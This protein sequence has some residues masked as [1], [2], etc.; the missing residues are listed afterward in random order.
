MWSNGGQNRRDTRAHARQLFFIGVQ[1]LYYLTCLAVA[2]L[3]SKIDSLHSTRVRISPIIEQY[4]AFYTSEYKN[5]AFLARARVLVRESSKI[6][7][8]RLCLWTL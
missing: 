8:N 7:K 2:L 4:H 3:W 5:L 1:N 6:D